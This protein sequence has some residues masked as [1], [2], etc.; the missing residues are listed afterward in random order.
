MRPTRGWEHCCTPPALQEPSEVQLLQHFPE[1]HLPG[2][3]PWSPWE[4]REV[5]VCTAPRPGASLFAVPL[6]TSY[7]S[8]TVLHL[9]TGPLAFSMV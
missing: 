7:T 8:V 9:P 4:G 1:L 6:A 3:Q 2:Q 5:G